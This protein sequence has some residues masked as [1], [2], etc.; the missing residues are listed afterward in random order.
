MA[1]MPEKVA[2]IEVR[3]DEGE[4][5]FGELKESIDEIK[6]TLKEEGTFKHSSERIEFRALLSGDIEGELLQ[7]SEKS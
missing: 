4:K 6:E 1:T 2:K 3:L 7:V 5:E